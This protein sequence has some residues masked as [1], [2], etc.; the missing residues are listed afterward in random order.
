MVKWLKLFGD[1]YLGFWGLSLVLLALQELPY[2]LMPLFKLESNP[3]MEMPES[4]GLLN[5]CEKL[6]GSLCIAL[7]AFIVRK[8]AVMFSTGSGAGRIGFIAAITVLALNYAGWLLYF[9]GH[10]STALMLFFLVAL[11][12]LYYA[13]IGLWRGN[14]PLLLTGV[15]FGMVH[16]AHVYGNLMM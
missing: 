1:Q 5:A 15:A 7:M 9:T 3:I 2:M 14:W 6:L 11:P 16:F 12:P 10:Q 13:C 8:D 4:S